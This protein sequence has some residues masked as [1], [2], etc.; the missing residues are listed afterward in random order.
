MMAR[1]L[2][3]LDAGEGAGVRLQR[4][5]QVK[6]IG[7]Q[8]QAGDADVKQLLLAYAAFGGEGAAEGARHGE[9]DGG[10]EHHRAVG[11]RRH[12]VE[13]L[14]VMAQ[15]AEQKGTGPG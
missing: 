6:P 11:A 10:K 2:F 14:F 12:R 9:A 3:A 4:E 1:A 7:Q 5:E 15:S 8:Q 13:A